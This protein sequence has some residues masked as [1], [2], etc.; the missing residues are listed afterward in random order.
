M[1]EINARLESFNSK[2][3]QKLPAAQLACQA[4]VA[5]MKSISVDI[6]NIFHRVRF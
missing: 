2:S 4:Y 5:A 6:Q 1:T 3:E